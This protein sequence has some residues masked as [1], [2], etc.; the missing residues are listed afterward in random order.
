MTSEPDSKPERRPP[1][2]ELTATEV[3][4]SASAAQSGAPTGDGATG[5]EASDKPAGE[6]SAGRLKSHAISAGFGAIA[7][8]AIIGGLWI[9]GFGPSHE[10]AAPVTPS[11]PQITSPQIAASQIA[12]DIS[13]RLDKIESV[14]QAQQALTSRIAAAEAQTKSLADSL[15]ALNQHLDEIAGTSQSAAKQA[16]A[17]RAAAEA[18]KSADQ[19]ALQRGD[20]DALA[21]RIAALESTVKSL[22]DNAAHPA[23]GA[24]DQA[25]RLAIAAAA[26]RAAV[27]RGAPYQAE[28][29]AVQSFGANAGAT[30][31]LQSFAA[32]GVPSAAMLAADL[33]TL[34]PALRHASDTAADGNGFLGRLEAN[35]QQLVRITPV[36]APPGNDPSSVVTRIDLDAT[37]ADIA[38]ALTDI[39]ALPEA[40]KPLAADWVKKAQARSD[41]LAASGK[42][43]ADALAALIKPAAQ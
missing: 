30:A 11:A 18:A 20:L 22:S 6:R 21:N 37:R 29:A 10:A 39:A 9:A 4:K 3:G 8:A 16:D 7:M 36:D 42:I 14:L 32:T 43:A 23:S 17:A 19:T 1:T 15:T 41:A 34:T 2:I 27:E 33:A 24:D 38:A 5:S 35:A 28:L 25:A 13:A 31:P 26:L 12:P 40:A